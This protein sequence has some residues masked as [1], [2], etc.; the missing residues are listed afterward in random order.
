LLAN[1]Y[2]SIPSIPNPEG[3]ISAEAELRRVGI[4]LMP[5]NQLPGMLEDFV[6]ALLPADDRLRAKAETIVA[7]IE[8]EALHL[9]PIAQHAKALIHTWLAWQEIPGQPMGLAI[10]RQVLQHD[11]PTALAFVSW[12]RRF[13]ALPDAPEVA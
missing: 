11:T 2:R 4:W 7:E 3:W 1:G 5:N 12:L 8:R 10:T 9:Y 13:F 6:W